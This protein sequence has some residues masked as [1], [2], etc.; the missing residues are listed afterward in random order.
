MPESEILRRERELL[1]AVAKA[2]RRCQASV[3]R[4]ADVAAL[5]RDIH[6]EADHIIQT[7][8]HDGIVKS[9]KNIKRWAKECLDLL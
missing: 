9:A 5:L 7:I 1:D 4:T 8:G 3:D 2:T 6:Y